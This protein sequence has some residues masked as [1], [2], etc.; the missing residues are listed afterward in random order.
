MNYVYARENRVDQ[1]APA[2]DEELPTSH[3]RQEILD[4]MP[5]AAANAAMLQ[6]DRSTLDP[7]KRRDHGETAGM[8]D[9]SAH[10][11]EAQIIPI[12]KGVDPR[13]D[14]DTETVSVTPTVAKTGGWADLNLTVCVVT[15]C[16]D[17]N[18]SQMENSWSDM[19]KLLT[20]GA[21]FTGSMTLSEYQAATD[22]EKKAA[23]DG[24][25]WIPCS[26][27][28]PA[29]KR[30]Q[31]NMNLAFAMVLDI[32]I[33]MA[34]E[35]VVA[36]LGE[37]EYV[38][39]SSYS[40]SPEKPK[41]RVVIP[42]R[43]PIPAQD[44]PRVF[45][46]FQTRF[47]GALDPACG[48]D[49]ARMY[50]LPACPADAESIFVAR[51]HEGELL[52]AA[53]VLSD[54]PAVKSLPRPTTRAPK[55]IVAPLEGA[56]IEAG[57]RNNDLF[58]TACLL[59]RQGNTEEEILRR[60][61]E[62]NETYVPP[63]DE[64]EVR[65]VVANAM[66]K[67]EKD[68]LSELAT[69]E[70]RVSD[71]N[72]KY[73]WVE[74]QSRVFRFKFR[75]FVTIDQLRQQYANDGMVVGSGGKTKWQ[76]NADIWH[77]S[78]QRR[79]HANVDFQPGKSLIVNNCINLWEGWR[80]APTA[81]DIAP[82]NEML[83]HL[84]GDD[85]VARK[86]FEQWVAYPLQNPGAKLTTAVVLWSTRQGVGKSMVGE[87]IGQ[88]YGNNF[89]TITSVELHAQFNGWMRDCQ[90]ALGEENSSSSQRADSNRLKFL[91]TGT[92]ISVNE[93]NQPAIELRNCANFIFTSNHADAFYLEDTD[94]RLFIW[95]IITGRKNDEFYK[96]FM[97]WRDSEGGLPALMDHLLKVD[98][99]GFQPK[100]NAPMT[101]A[102]L[103]MIAN[104]KTDLERWLAEAVEDE[105]SVKAVL[106]KEVVHVEDLITAYHRTG[107]GRVNSTS[108]ARAFSRIAHYAKRRVS[109]GKR[110]RSNLMSVVNHE[111]WEVADNDAWAAEYAKPTPIDMSV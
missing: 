29:G 78:P 13:G 20:G 25:A 32:D 93:K 44:L 49:P 2:S 26:A 70:E 98:L 33:G 89:R 97:D 11:P 46:V 95:E 102:K 69:H 9:S 99:D 14:S 53:M 31:S 52:D 16:K 105:E 5:Q 109:C 60:C 59:A 57:G 76:T 8:A 106:G 27:I 90:F 91:I 39:H 94:R 96:R 24:L 36:K 23:K 50:Y 41:W 54:T 58:K 110:R 47:G 51:H 10:L 21:L 68:M 74:K 84:F 81:G 38:L 101:Q 104:S 73:A 15:S 7:E 22:K 111:K 83:Q 3:V 103:D 42:F 88:L 40:H 12:R 67:V 45:D 56:T 28:D 71:M 61:V 87:T 77:R 37:Y 19:V 55:T 1:T 66:K 86:W 4:T 30:E 65:S 62:R 17:I 79:T 80:V 82:W 85:E 107:C 48:H 43:T 108:V 63:L 100:G 75:D 72:D 6:A 64:D 34:L 92:T 35:D 18:L